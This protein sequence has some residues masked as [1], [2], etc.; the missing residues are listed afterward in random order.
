MTSETIHELHSS[1]KLFPFLPNTL[2]DLDSY[3]LPTHTLDA[4]E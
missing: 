1:E 2:G 3:L 4:G